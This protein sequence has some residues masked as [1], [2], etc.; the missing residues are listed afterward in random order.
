MN[1]RAS[2]YTTWS[3]TVVTTGVMTFIDVAAFCTL[4]YLRASEELRM[5]VFGA[6]PGL[7]P[8]LLGNG[9]M[10]NASLIRL[11]VPLV[12]Q[13]VMGGALVAA[14]HKHIGYGMWLA[15]LVAG[16]CIS[17]MIFIVR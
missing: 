8:V 6:G 9:G 10:V 17:G 13:C 14:G 3:H 11:V 7:L 1:I 2:T 5:P 16:A 4:L 15:V 12:I